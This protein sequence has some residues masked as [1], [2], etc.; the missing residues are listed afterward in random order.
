LYLPYNKIHLIANC[1]TSN[2]NNDNNNNNNDNNN[3]NNVDNHILFSYFE[4]FYFY[5]AEQMAKYKTTTTA[6]KCQ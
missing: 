6:E 5:G 2:N 3:N 1:V 4:C